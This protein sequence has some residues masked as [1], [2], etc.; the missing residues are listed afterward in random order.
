VEWRHDLQLW[1]SGD[2]AAAE[3]LREYITPFVHG[4]LLA[5]FP[6]HVANSQTSTV[7]DQAMAAVPSPA[8]D[9]NFVQQAVATA[10][11]FARLNPT[12]KAGERVTADA[13]VNEARRWLERVR[14]LEE[15]SREVV[16]WRMTGGIPGEELVTVLGADRLELRVQ[17]ERGVEETMGVTFDLTGDEYLWRF[18]GEPSTQL[19]RLE[20]I[21]IVLRFDP[22]APL[23]PISGKGSNNAATFQDLDVPVQ[24]L[25]QLDE[26]RRPKRPDASEPRSGSRQVVSS[27]EK[28][29]KT[30][31]AYNLPAAARGMPSS[32]LAAHEQKSRTA[33]NPNADITQEAP[34]VVWPSEKGVT[35][36]DEERPSRRMATRPRPSTAPGLSMRPS[37]TDEL[38]TEGPHTEEVDGGKE[39]H[40]TELLQVSSGE[41]PAWRGPS[42][43]TGRRKL[44]ALPLAT[45]PLRM[46]RSSSLMRLI[47][48]ALVGLLVGLA[49][50]WRLG[51]AS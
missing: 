15:A 41:T 46:P 19:A 45:E 50:L 29:E 31:G 44:P 39:A 33:K 34:A 40:Q 30:K 42:E 14:Q 26:V 36:N 8:Q 7:L 12:S 1:R 18:E 38:E 16:I 17:L 28:D 51:R 47:G 49:L 32:P 4:V 21:A 5:R 25:P 37:V 23:E 27:Y 6:H 2:S 3:R 10:R 43:L 24:P 11:R 9:T 35:T 22:R 20:T 48:F 13:L